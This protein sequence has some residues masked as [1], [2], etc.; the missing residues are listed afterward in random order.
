LRHSKVLIPGLKIIDDILK[1]LPD[2]AILRGQLTDLRI[3]VAAL[4]AKDK[5][6]Q[7]KI[8][9]LEKKLQDITSVVVDP[10]ENQ[11][12]S[13]LAGDFNGAT[14]DQLARHFKL[15][16]TKTQHHLNRLFDAKLVYGQGYTDARP[17]EWHLGTKGQ[18]YVVENNLI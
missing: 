11:I 15:H 17:H 2:N 16:P 7:A 1:G 14:V 10:F 3:Q 6:S 9:E 18:A 5:D 8:V 4:E 13:A 12:L